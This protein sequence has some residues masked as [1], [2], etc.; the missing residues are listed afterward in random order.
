MKLIDLTYPFTDLM[1]TYPGD[2]KPSLEQ[3]ARIE[4]E[5]YTDHWLQTGMHVGTHMDAPAHMIKGGRMVHELPLGGM[6]GKGRVVDARGKKSLDI[7]ILRDFEIKKD[8]IVLFCTG[9]SKKYHTKEYF[10]N[11]PVMTEALASELVR[12]K[13][14]MVGFD[15][16]SPDRAPFAV[17]KILLGAGVL[18]IENLTNLEALLPRETF[19]VEALPMRI[20]ADAAPARVI[21]FV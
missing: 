7:L 6:Y 2:P 8:D 17:H 13:I 18:I 14:K 5:G 1:P 19:Q 9:F 16:P 11:F 15:T 20:A 21:A 12:R 4:R 10:T 3:F